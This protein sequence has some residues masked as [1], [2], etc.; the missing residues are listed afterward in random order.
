[1]IVAGNSGKITI[2][3]WKLIKS[4]SS[5]KNSN[6][7]NLQEI[8]QKLNQREKYEFLFEL[9]MPSDIKA[10]HILRSSNLLLACSDEQ[11]LIANFSTGKEIAR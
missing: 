6:L 10:V 8:N 2:F 11:L 3:A 1:M 5:S 4:D 7:I 9:L